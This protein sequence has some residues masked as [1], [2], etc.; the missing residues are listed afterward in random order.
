MRSHHF[1]RPRPGVPALKKPPRSRG[2]G[3]RRARRLVAAGTVVASIVSVGV[4]ATAGT[5]VADPSI[6]YL[7]VGSDTTQDVMNAFANDLS[8]NLVGSFDAVNPVTGASHDAITAAKT[9]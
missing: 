9:G 3:R 8:G 7:V 6:T 2:L 4:A 5:A 1:G